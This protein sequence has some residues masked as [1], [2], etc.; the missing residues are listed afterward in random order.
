MS[1]RTNGRPYNSPRR[2]EQAEATRQTVVAA[3][4]QLFE[5]DGYPATSIAAVAKAAQV[6]PRTVYLG[7]DTKAGLL[8][9]VWNSA[10][11]GDVHS[12]PLAH[13]R[14]FPQAPP[15]PPPPHAPPPS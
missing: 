11:H 9:A 4:R 15:N 7:F 3:A 1:S 6:T 5:H 2:R 10:L 14:W 12:P 8:R 13:P